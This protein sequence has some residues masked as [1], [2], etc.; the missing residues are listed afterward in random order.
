M[1]WFNPFS[2]GRSAPSAGASSVV[3]A[4]GPPDLSEFTR[5]SWGMGSLSASDVIALGTV[6][7]GCRPETR[8]EHVPFDVID[9][10]LWHPV[11]KAAVSTI[12]APAT[13]PELYYLRGDKKACAEVDASLRPLLVTQRAPL[14]DQ[15]VR[16]Y[17]TG[18]APIVLDYGVSNLSIQVDTR[19]GEGTRNRN[20]PGH[21][22]YVRSHELWP[23]ECQLRVEHDRLLAVESGGQS[24]GGEDLEDPGRIRAFLAIWD[25]QYGRWIGHGA[26]RRAYKDWIEEGMARLW[27]IRYLERSV[28]LPR[29]GYAPEGD[30]TIGGQKVSAIKLLRAQIMSL[31]NG[32]TITL[33]STLA[34][35]NQPAWRFQTL[36]VPDRHQ[37]FEYAI[38][39]RGARMFTAALCPSDLNKASEEQAMDAVQRVCDFAARTLTRIVN[40]P[41]RL[42]YGASAP[43]VQVLA[44][45]IP[46]RKLRIVQQVF[47]TS[48]QAQQ[49]T[50]D[51]K[52]YTLAE[53]VHPEILDQ[54]GV[55]ART[56]EEAAHEAP[57]A[58]PPGQ[59]GRPL[60]VASDRE[61]R[62]DD[63]RTI[64]GEEDTGGEDVEREERA[65]D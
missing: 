44:N 42:R 51:G 34:A 46:K 39:S 62:R 65:S 59:P 33:P 18:V 56:V 54:L 5:A 22:H 3:L 10:M 47:S 60:D 20:L 64:E 36:D 31:R 61:E 6:G 14:L 55:K 58:P 1:A 19:D 35:D 27:E 40:V 48:A 4:A 23:G 57:T 28:D 63:S 50:A 21:V 41:L 9:A 43:F 17:A 2:W 45:D 12:T 15:I 7:M 30:I 29:V 37:I 52:V 25:P 32:S 13:D 26:C 38:N 11:M 24:Y 16:A 8:P 53:L 49:R